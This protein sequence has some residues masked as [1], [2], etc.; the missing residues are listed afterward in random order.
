LIRQGDVSVEQRRGLKRLLPYLGGVADVRP[1][2]LRFDLMKTQR[3]NAE[4]KFLLLI[5]K[6]LFEFMLMAEDN[7]ERR[8]RAFLPD[9]KV[10]PRLYEEFVCGYY[11][12]HHPEFHAGKRQINWDLSVEPETSFL[13]K[14][15]TDITLTYEGKTLIIDT[16]WY[17][18]TMASYWRESP[19]SEG[20]HKYHSGNMYQIYSYVT[21]AAKGAQGSVEGVL[22]YAKTDEP[23]TPDGTYTIG[24]NDI[25]VKT[26]A[27]SGDFES[28]SAQLE[29]LAAPLKQ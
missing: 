13:P 24:G 17:G 2:E 22:L 10:M 15:E 16:K 26:L 27:L 3:V 7:G 23:V 5:C 18:K 19:Y 28:I 4:Y 8:L 12:Y 25:S 21:N 11:R 9:D 29:K 20:K 1:S 6:L 14:M